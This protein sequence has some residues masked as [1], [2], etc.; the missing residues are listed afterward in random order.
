MLRVDIVVIGC[1][2]L[3]LAK[4]IMCAPSTLILVV[5]LVFGLVVINTLASPC[6][7]F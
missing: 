3:L 6:G 1:V 2:L 7:E 5:N 4:L